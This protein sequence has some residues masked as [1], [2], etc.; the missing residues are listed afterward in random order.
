MR[1][2][3]Q[4]AV[5][6]ARLIALALGHVLSLGCASAPTEGR[7]NDSG[8]DATGGG[9]GSSPGASGSATALAA[10]APSAGYVRRLT[11]LEYDNTV[12][13]LLSVDGKHSANFE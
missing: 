4:R 3:V 1:S 6:S 10:D 9:G 13:D 5:S 12:L 7:V 8:N 2:R 11:H